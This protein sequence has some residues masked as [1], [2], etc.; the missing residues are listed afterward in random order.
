MYK[1]SLS[2]D[3]TVLAVVYHSGMFSLWDIPSLRIKN[4]WKQQDQPG[5]DEVNPE[6][7]E[8]PKRRKQMKG[9]MLGLSYMR[10][11]TLMFHIKIGIFYTTLNSD[12]EMFPYL[13]VCVC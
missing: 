3:G 7:T 13:S 2:P 8:N 5:F 4:L 6:V 12:A 1:M 9:T 10:M 11:F